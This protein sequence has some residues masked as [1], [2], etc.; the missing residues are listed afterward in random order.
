MLSRPA[1]SRNPVQSHLPAQRHPSAPRLAPGRPRTAEPEPFDH[2]GYLITA[3]REAGLS[4]EQARQQLS[5]LAA[6]DV[7][8]G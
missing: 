6:G 4:E 8:S 3:L 2:Q 1:P 5:R 7:W